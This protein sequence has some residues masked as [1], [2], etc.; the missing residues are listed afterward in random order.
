MNSL[1]ASWPRRLGFAALVFGL[2]AFA[3]WQHAEVN[4]ASLSPENQMLRFLALPG[5]FAA[6]VLALTTACAGLSKAPK[7]DLSPT[8]GRRP[9][10][11]TAQVMGIQWMNPLIRRDYPTEWQLLWVQ[12]LAQPNRN[13][14][15]VRERREKYSSVQYVSSIVSNVHKQKRFSDIFLQYNEEF[16]RPLGRRYAMNGDYFYTIHGRD[17]KRWRELH[18]IHVEFAIPDTPDLPPEQA[19]KTVRDALNRE[20][21]FHH[22]PRLSTANIPADVRIT[23]GGA[24]AGFTSLAAA[25]D[26]LEAHP[27]KTVW[28]MNWDAPEYPDDESLAENCVLLVLAGPAYESGREPLARIGR[29]AVS[30]AQHFK[31]DPHASRAAQAWQ[32]A[33]GAATTAAG[34]E[35]QALGHVIHDAAA[36]SAEAGQRVATL[37][38][39]LITALPE[40]DFM[41]QSF[42]TAKLLGDMRAGSALTDVALAVAWTHQKGQPVLVAGTR[43]AERA[44][45]VVVTPPDRA[46][47]AD[48]DKDWFRARG[49]GNAYLPWWGLRKQD[50]WSK[51]MQG[52]SD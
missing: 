34:V 45:A 43:E 48:P 19:A 25:F 17:P 40:F 35:P 49:E 21:E 7:S 11:F 52:F 14:E 50:D 39:G 29:P 20:F 41:A 26:Y 18:G 1:F 23:A 44:V 24:N 28:V 36:G 2:A 37:G 10:P 42:N 3:S 38:Q 6:A 12:G 4:T 31:A 16:Y 13:D 8:E 9:A 33:L 27:D 47:R 46:R 15:V 30:E 51:T 32:A 22:V 5:L